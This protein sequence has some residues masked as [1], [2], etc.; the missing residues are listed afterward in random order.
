MVTFF[1]VSPYVLKYLLLYNLYQ[2]IKQNIFNITH[3]I[4]PLKAFFFCNKVTHKALK[5]TYNAK[6]YLKG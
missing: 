3:F 6:N 2:N 1:I 5:F 4:S